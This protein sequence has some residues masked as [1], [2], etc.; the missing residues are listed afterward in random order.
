M[1][2]S[3]YTYLVLSLIIFSCGGNSQKDTQSN[4]EPV[5]TEQESQSEVIPDTAEL[6]I[7]GNDLMQY[8]TDL[9]EVY[10]GQVVK[11]TL[12]HT[13]EMS[14]EAMG[15]NWVLLAPG[16]DKATFGSAAVSAKENNYI[17]KDMEN[18]VLASTKTIGG[19]ET[20]TIVFGAPAKG[21]YDYICSFPGHYGVMQGNFVVKPR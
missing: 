14:V 17:P 5:A 11:L 8:N 10:E 21:Y 9:L 2:L 1:K 15:H 3:Q 6:V 18:M 4:S 20:S 13:G 12:I 16:T 19:G 7:E